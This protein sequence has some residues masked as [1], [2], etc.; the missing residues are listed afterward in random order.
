MAPA[1]LNK[2]KKKGPAPENPAFK[3]VLGW[4]LTEARRAVSPEEH[5][6]AAIS[7]V[8]PED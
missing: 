2:N 3:E 8:S 7:D 5:E 4:V 1:P 6:A